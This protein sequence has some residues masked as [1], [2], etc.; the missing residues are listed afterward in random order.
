MRGFQ[1]SEAVD[2]SRCPNCDRDITPNTF[3]CE[4]SYEFATGRVLSDDASGQGGLP[5]WKVWFSFSGRINR[6]TYW[7]K[8]LIPLAILYGV[9]AM[10]LFIWQ[11]GYFAVSGLWCWV[12]LAVTAKRWHD[13]NKS[14]W[15]WWLPLVPFVG[16]IW[17]FVELGF[18]AGRPKD[19]VNRYGST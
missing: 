16:T 19:R 11:P 9:A 10:M 3:V 5:I 12:G 1:V 13:R 4:C 7:V 15:W 17:A 14:A 8:G 18:L 6:A 2:I